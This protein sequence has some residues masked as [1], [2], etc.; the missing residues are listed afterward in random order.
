[1]EQDELSAEPVFGR[2]WRF[3]FERGEFVLTPTGKVASS[4]G[5]EAWLEWCK[6]ALMTERYRYLAYSRDYGQEYEDYIGLGL[7][8]AATESE[9][10]RI[11]TETLMADP[12]TAKV[13]GFT[14]RW[15]GDRCS[16]A[17]EVT[18]VRDENGTL[19]GSVVNR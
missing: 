10:Q 11:S 17:C 5:R 13:G 12:R 19:Q 4:E 2:S 1:M 16:F 14:F 9:I 7:S 6:K 18:S 8:R 15:D 3:D